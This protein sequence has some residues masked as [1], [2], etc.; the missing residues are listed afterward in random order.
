MND[1]IT[2]S[3]KGCTRDAWK[4]QEGEPPFCIFHSPKVEEKKDEFI[5]KFSQYIDNNTD[6]DGNL[7]EIKCKGFIFPDDPENII[8]LIKHLID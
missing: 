5:I 1:R 4:P 6:K 3:Y 8:L 7:L 2:C